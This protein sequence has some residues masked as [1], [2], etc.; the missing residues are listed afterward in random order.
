MDG[1]FKLRPRDW[2]LRDAPGE[3]AGRYP[4]SPPRISHQRSPAS[5][6][7]NCLS[8][9]EWFDVGCT[10]V[11]IAVVFILGRTLAAWPAERVGFRLESAGSNFCERSRCPRDHSGMLC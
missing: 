3:A 1:E 4:G 7:R 10:L 11:S 2:A 9:Q 6:N 5:N 8:L